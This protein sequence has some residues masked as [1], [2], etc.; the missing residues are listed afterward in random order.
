MELLCGIFRNWGTTFL[1]V[2][3]DPQME[4]YTDRTIHFTD[5]RIERENSGG[6]FICATER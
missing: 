1:M 4:Q 5:G 6:R 3:H 2:S